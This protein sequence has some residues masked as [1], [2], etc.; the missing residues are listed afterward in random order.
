LFAD[1]SKR[2]TDSLAIFTACP[3]AVWMLCNLVEEL[4]V[5]GAQI[6]AFR[7]NLHFHSIAQAPFVTFSA[8]SA[9]NDPQ[10]VERTP[11][12]LEGFPASDNPLNQTA[13]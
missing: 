1:L 11:E 10:L 12:G 13:P 7:S 3:P 8:A 5:N 6:F 9:S 4:R 2:Y